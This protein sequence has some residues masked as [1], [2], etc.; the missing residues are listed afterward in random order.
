M[1]RLHLVGFTSEL[2][3][4]IFSAGTGARPGGFVVEVDAELLEAIREVLLRRDARSGAK[5]APAPPLPLA[6]SAHPGSALTPKEIQARLR[7]GR[8]IAEGAFEAGAGED[9]ERRLA[10]PV[11]AEQAH[12]VRRALATRSGSGDDGPSATLGEIVAASLAGR[13]VVL[14]ADELAGRWSAFRVQGGSWVV[15]Y[16]EPSDGSEPVARWAFDVRH[17]TLDALDD[18]AAALGRAGERPSP[19][20]AATTTAAARA[21]A[22]RTAATTTAATTTARAKA[23]A[24][25]KPT[26]TKGAATRATPSRTEA[27]RPD[28]PGEPAPKRRSTTGRKRASPAAS[29][30]TGS[31]RRA[32]SAP[33]PAVRAPG[34]G[35]LDL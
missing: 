32:V 7:A 9:W 15:E 23:T 6:A 35:R 12:V 26:A 8:S 21:M 11:F 2:D 27:A 34:E 24:A 29:P 17:G 16:R 5:R 18:V 3:G 1:Q 14:T 28:V 10:P 22:T 19:Q 30:K 25:A 4:L 20:R 31:S 13:G 33:R